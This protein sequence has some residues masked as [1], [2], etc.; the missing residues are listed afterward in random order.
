MLDD[1]KT[2]DQSPK[3]RG[4]VALD[5]Q[6][7][8]AMSTV[9]NRFAALEYCENWTELRLLG[10]QPQRRSY[11]SSFIYDKRLFVFG[12]LDIREGS[13]NTLYELPLSCLNE[14][15]GEDDLDS[16]PM[17][18]QHKWREVQTSGND[19]HRPGNV[20]YHSSVIFKDSMYIFG[21]NNTRP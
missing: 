5:Q 21:G 20:A 2:Y 19:A 16:K 17:V 15:F 13:L 1:V 8:A 11:H 9:N 6:S 10:K 3:M 12:G 18:S 4:T 7:P 14:V